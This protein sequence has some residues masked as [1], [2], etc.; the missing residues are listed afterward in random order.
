MPRE[1]VLTRSVPIA[2]ECSVGVPA[3]EVNEIL[4]ICPE[5]HTATAGVMKLIRMIATSAVK[6]GEEVNIFCEGLEDGLAA[7]DSRANFGQLDA[8][9]FDRRLLYADVCRVPGLA[10]EGKIISDLGVRLCI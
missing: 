3:R 6:N 4:P 1:D 8:Y 5:A 9:P 2:V 7:D 10:C